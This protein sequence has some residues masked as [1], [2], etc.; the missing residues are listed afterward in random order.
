MFQ[1]KFDKKDYVMCFFLNY[2]QF[3]R[4]VWIDDNNI[5]AHFC[6]SAGTLGYK[7]IFR[8]GGDAGS[9]CPLWYNSF[10]T[11]KIY[12]MAKS[13][14]VYLHSHVVYFGC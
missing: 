1:P 14:V 2:D 6:G 11:N 7:H 10:L 8:T 4:S 5:F 13:H 12:K 3:E 9:F